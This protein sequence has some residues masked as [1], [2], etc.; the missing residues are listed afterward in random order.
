MYDYNTNITLGSI[1]AERRRQQPHSQ[2]R[3]KKSL[4]PRLFLFFSDMESIRN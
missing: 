2:A 1:G 4:E 3:R